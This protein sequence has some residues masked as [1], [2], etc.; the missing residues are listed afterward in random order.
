MALEWLGWWDRSHGT[1]A[2]VFPANPRTLH[3]FAAPSLSLESRDLAG[4][5]E[6]QRLGWEGVELV[7]LC[8]GRLMNVKESEERKE[9]WDGLG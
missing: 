2:T 3:H 4:G 1:P 5:A 6:T 7:T 9:R 8:A